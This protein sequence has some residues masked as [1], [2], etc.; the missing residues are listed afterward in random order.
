VPVFNDY[1]PAPERSTVNT[2]PATPAQGQF[3][4]RLVAERDLNEAVQV[5]IE[6]ARAAWVEGTLTRFQASGLIELLKAQPYKRRGTAHLPEGI[7]VL[8]GS[9]YKVQENQAGTGSY[10]K[11]WTGLEWQY[12]GPLSKTRLTALDVVTAEEAARF[13]HVTGQCV[14]CSRKLTDERSIQVGYGPKCATNNGLP[15][16]PQRLRAGCQR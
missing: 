3:L 5:S 13:G 1:Q 12:V 15:W 6:R 9:Y 16:G 10:V 4:K 11:V 14:F 2:N 8:D 7:Y